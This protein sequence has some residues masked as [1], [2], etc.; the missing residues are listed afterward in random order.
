[1][2]LC[3]THK[4]S[5][6]HPVKEYTSLAN[7]LRRTFLEA[8]VRSRTTFICPGLSFTKLLMYVMSVSS[9]TSTKFFLGARLENN[10]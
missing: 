10:S 5:F 8:S 1:M 7:L 6:P 4:A 2:K 3:Y 9:V